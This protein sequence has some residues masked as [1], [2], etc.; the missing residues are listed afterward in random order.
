MHP[1]HSLVREQ[2][3]MENAV[4]GF[5]GMRENPSIACQMSFKGEK[6]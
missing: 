6:E 2:R 1:F 5:P 3:L 4:A